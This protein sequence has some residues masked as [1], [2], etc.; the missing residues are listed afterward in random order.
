MPPLAREAVATAL[1]ADAEASAMI[2]AAPHDR[3]VIGRVLGDVAGRVR[4]KQLALKKKLTTDEKIL[5]SVLQ[6][7]GEEG[8]S[9]VEVAVI[10]WEPDKGVYCA[11]GDAGNPVL[12]EV[13]AQFATERGMLCGDDWAQQIRLVL[14]ALD[15]CKARRDGRVYWAPSGALPALQA[16]GKAVALAGLDLVIAENKDMGLAERIAA[17]GLC[18]EISELEERS[19][20]ADLLT[21][22][23]QEV[24]DRATRLAITLCA[25]DQARLEALVAKVADKRKRKAERKAQA[26]APAAA[27]A[28]AAAPAAAAA[29]PAPPPLPPPAAPAAPAFALEHGGVAYQLGYA[30]EAAG[31]MHA[32]DVLGG[33]EAPVF[34]WE[35]NGTGHI[36]G[37]AGRMYSTVKL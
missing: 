15:G 24:R 13:A 1:A 10:A 36:C 20:G 2:P 4:G 30:G 29:L 14:R 6:D 19:V 3:T 11:A 25:E 7:K 35:P 8:G 9:M 27:E 5:H 18:D 16:L 32:Y 17:D 37:Y 12:A 21:A 22:R 23:V 28:P 34:D 33:V 31:G 26:P